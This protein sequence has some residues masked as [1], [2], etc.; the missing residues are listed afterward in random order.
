VTS[1]SFPIAGGDFGHGGAASRALKEL[2]K[3]VGADEARLVR[4][5]MVAAYEA[6]MNVII[7]A[8][9]G[10]MEAWIGADTVTVE[11]R[12]EGP[13]IA[14][15]ELAQ[16]PGYSTAPPAARALGFGAGLGLPNMKS[17][18]DWFT[19]ESSVGQ[20]TRVRFSLKLAPQDGA[21]RR[22]VAVRVR[23]ERCHECL[24]CVVACPLQALRVRRGSPLVLAHR[25][26]ECTACI[27]ACPSGALAVE[28]SP[29]EPAPLGAGECLVTPPAALAQLGSGVP[30]A[31][32]AARLAERGIALRLTDAWEESL[33]RAAA[34]WG[35]AR[36]ATT[37]IVPTCPA[38]LS[39]VET[40]HP[41][42]IDLC[43]PFLGPLEAAALDAPADARVVCLCPA[44]RRSLL[45]LGVEA[46]RLLGA[47]ALAAGL[48]GGPV[49]A[50]AATAA[51][52]GA[53]TLPVVRVTGL[54]QVRRT[55]E[56]LEDGQLADVGL[57][58][59]WACADGC[60]GSALLPRCNAAVAAARWRP[61]PAA[62]LPAA[63]ARTAPLRSRPGLRLAP[64][65]ATAVERLGRI[66]AVTRSLPGRDCARCGAPTC[67]AFA[68][69]VVL[70]RAAAGACP[71][72]AAPAEAT[73]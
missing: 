14:D 67:R 73:P 28:E 52:D 44:Q 31:V 51:A 66:D 62:E 22:A 59:L 58:E 46:R 49:A 34:A 55:L 24:R 33:R 50:P 37:V 70:E 19:L 29:T 54:A 42:L 69:D 63:R 45:E 60:F 13:G 35:A 3:G 38:V 15:L 12:D 21:A 36:G 11:V 5:L 26:V 39:L 10:V 53:A 71:F 61:A 1:W 6:E 25:C 9:R 68:E 43:A 4:R 41:G 7:H 8:R 30:A 23:A 72:P 32:A 40:A 17:H 56:E 18:S 64:D 65:M 16:R 57:L 47:A 27:A 2:L 48:A 20:G